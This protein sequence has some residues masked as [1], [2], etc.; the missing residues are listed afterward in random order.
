MDWNLIYETILTFLALAIHQTFHMWQFAA[1]RLIQALLALT[2]PGLLTSCTDIHFYIID[3]G[4]G[5]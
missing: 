2:K 5:P 3:Q 1:H 4:M